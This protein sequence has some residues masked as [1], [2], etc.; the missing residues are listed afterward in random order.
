MSARV[1]LDVFSGLPNPEWSISEAEYR[2]LFGLVTQLRAG[3]F[4]A[5][6]EAADWGYK[7][8]VITSPGRPTI[9][10]VNGVEARQAYVRVD[11]QDGVLIDYGRM[12]EPWLLRSSQGIVERLGLTFAELTKARNESPIKGLP[13]HESLGFACQTGV[14]YPS[15][16]DRS[17]WNASSSNC[18]N[19]ANNHMAPGATPAVPGPNSATSWTKAKMI[20]AATLNDKLDHLPDTLPAACPMNP[21]SHYLVI[22]LRDPLGNGSFTDFHCLRLDRSGGWSHKD[23]AGP[24]RKRDDVKKEITD[25]RQAMFK[26]PLTFVGFFQSTKGVRQIS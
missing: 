6:F 17:V 13:G 4:E 25:L 9:R 2:Q 23:G 10:I 1:Y 7:G 5:G 22:C 21:H 3:R 14:A 18:Y 8:F 20:K 19:Y 24:V 16:S 11:G 12:I 26:I 15:P